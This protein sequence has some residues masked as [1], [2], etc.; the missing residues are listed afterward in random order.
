M[1]KTIHIKGA[2]EI[3]DTYNFLLD[4][5]DFLLT[6]VIDVVS[7]YTTKNLII[8]G[9]KKQ[10]RWDWDNHYIEVFDPEKKKWEQ[11]KYTI[12]SAEPGYNPNIGENHYIEEINHFISA[13]EGKTEFINTIEKD[14]TVLKLLYAIEKSD[15]DASFVNLQR[16]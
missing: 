13:V 5:N 11:T 7:S 10:L 12:S 1:R 15:R 6:A 14:H 4:Y 3:D 9:D 8:N 16:G 2:E